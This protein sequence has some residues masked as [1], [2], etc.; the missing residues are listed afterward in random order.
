MMGKQQ[1]SD[2]GAPSSRIDFDLII[3]GFFTLVVAFAL[4]GADNIFRDGDVSWHVAAGQW[5]IEHRQVPLVDPFSYSA[6]GQPWI[7]HE[8]LSEVIMG[9]AYN[10]AGFAGLTIL[11]AL[12]MSLTLLIVG[13]EVRRWAEPVV[14]GITLFA[15]SMALIPFLLARPMV[16]AWPV[17]AF[18]LVALIRA[19]AHDRAPPLYLAAVML[20]WVN[21]HAS[22]ALGIG[23][24]GPFAL[25]ALIVSKDR[26]RAFIGWLVVGVACLAAAFLNPNFLRGVLIPFGAFGSSNINLIQEFRPTD[27]TY[28]PGFEVALL[29]LIGAC[30]WVGAKVAPLRLFVVLLLLHLAL[31]H[32][33]H[34]ALF[35]IA[36]AIIVAPAIGRAIRGE[37]E[38]PPASYAFE[39]KPMGKRL[40]VAGAMAAAFMAV[41]AGRLWS[42]IVPPESSINPISALAHVPPALT[43]QHVLN[44][45]SLGGPLILRGIRPFMDGRTD[46]YGEPFFVEFTKVQAG[47]QAALD[48]VDGKWQF[49]WTIFP[50]ARTAIIA[51]MDKRPGWR[52]LYSDQYAVVHVRTTPP[53]AN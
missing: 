40:L 13:L 42:P 28:T 16:L 15:L 26:R 5:M 30:L 18:W 7:A 45:Y 11:F 39:G 9:W 52:R 51:L 48:R 31:V 36:A 14:L 29:L 34:Q 17:L 24:M 53:A 25:E 1:V 23:L 43:R 20:L 3:I 21:L 22:F 2:A 8:W 4:G 32:M 19:R 41:A 50:P 47:D 27:M 38:R 46:V 44:D 49:G 10:L 35:A 12:A 33:R 6:L 37:A